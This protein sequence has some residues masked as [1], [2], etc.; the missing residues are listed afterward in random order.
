MTRRSLLVLVL[1]FWSLIGCATASG[2]EGGLVPG[3]LTLTGVVVFREP[4]ALPPDAVLTVTLEDVSRADAPATTLAQQTQSAVSGSQVPFVLVYP[5]S[6]VTPGASYAA[7]ARVTVGDRLLFTTAG[8]N[9][10]DP[11]NPSP[12]ELV[13]DSVDPADVTPDVSLTDTYWKLVEVDGSGVDVTEQMR[14]PHIVL[15]GQN[16]RFHGSGGVNRLLGGYTVDGN[17]VTF[18]Q[19]ASTMMAGPPEAMQQE[20]RIVAALG[21]V[22]GFQIAG[23]RLTLVDEASQPVLNAVALVLN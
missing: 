22:R 13:V 19:V 5:G 12:I 18:S 15:D 9:P 23:D 3:S 7:R 20:Q 16:G 2:D 8:R 10:V 17:A 21:R 1:G 6:A 4:M 14:E 11:L